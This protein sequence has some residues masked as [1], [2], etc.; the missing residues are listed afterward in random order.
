MESLTRRQFLQASTATALALSLSGRAQSTLPQALTRA[1]LSLLLLLGASLVAAPAALA[2]GILV[3]PATP[4][5]AT[6]QANATSNWRAAKKP[7]SGFSRQKT[8]IS[9][10]CAS[11]P[12]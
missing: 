3:T 5:P 2:N 9:V 6:S 12:R 7:N 1:L 8:K 4:A 11:P 10:R